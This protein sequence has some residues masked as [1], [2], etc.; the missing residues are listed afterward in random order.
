MAERCRPGGSS[1]TGLED[2][3]WLLVSGGLLCMRMVFLYYLRVFD[4]YEHDLDFK[5]TISE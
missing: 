2:R 4:R 1:L 5:G 3:L